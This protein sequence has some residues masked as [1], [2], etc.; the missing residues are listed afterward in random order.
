MSYENLDPQ[1]KAIC[2]AIIA[3]KT[4]EEIKAEFSVDD[5]KCS[6]LHGHI[7]NNPPAGEKEEGADESSVGEEGGDE[8]KS[9]DGATE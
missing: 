4:D 6:Q 1:D 3:G 2:G 7:A 8:G 9:A 5:D